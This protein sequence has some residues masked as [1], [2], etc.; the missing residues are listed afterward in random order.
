M[1]TIPSDP[2]KTLLTIS[3]G[4]IA[5]SWY[6]S[7]DWLLIA[8]LVIGAVGIFS[9]TLSRQVERGW[10]GLAQMLGL[11]VPNILLSL[12]FFFILS[13]IALLSR[14]GK[15]NPLNLKND[16]DSTFTERQTP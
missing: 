3:T 7:Y 15:K 9:H 5:V 1:Q 14:I 13:P 8:A 6:Y 11:I 4:L 16:K 12:V 2:P 10:F